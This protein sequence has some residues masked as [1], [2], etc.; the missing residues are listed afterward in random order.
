MKFSLIH[1][2]LRRHKPIRWCPQA[3]IIHSGH[4]FGHYTVIIQVITWPIV[5]H[6]CHH[7]H[8][9]KKSIPSI[10]DL[11]SKTFPTKWPWNTQ[12]TF[13]S[14]HGPHTFVYEYLTK[15]PL[16][17][18]PGRGRLPRVTCHIFLLKALKWTVLISLPSKRSNK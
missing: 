2:L 18:D 9:K 13:C 14:G 4:V 17:A 16:S 10:F 11:Q 7:G 8:K 15:W 1:E 12:K 3:Q 5:A 6:T